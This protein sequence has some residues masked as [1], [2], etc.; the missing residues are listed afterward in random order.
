M[1][2]WVHNDVMH[3]PRE[4]LEDIETASRVCGTGHPEAIA[5]A[6]SEIDALRLSLTNLVVAAGRMADGWAEADDLVKKQLWRDL[7]S[8]AERADT[9]HGIYPL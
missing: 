9:R 1:C 6:L 3:N 2:K 7:H 5:W 4:L 8:A